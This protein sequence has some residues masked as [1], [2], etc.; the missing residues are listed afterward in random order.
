MSSPDKRVR[1]KSRWLVAAGAFLL[2]A[3]LTSVLGVVLFAPAPSG[4]A[5]LALPDLLHGG[6]GTGIAALLIIA[7]ALKLAGILIAATRTWQKRKQ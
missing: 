6:T 5:P 1:I 2:L 3:T 7:L 4:E